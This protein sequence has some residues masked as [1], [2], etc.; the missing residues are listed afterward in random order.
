MPEAGACQTVTCP[1]GRCFPGDGGLRVRRGRRKLPPMLTRTNSI[2]LGVFL[3]AIVATAGLVYRGS[4][5]EPPPEING[6]LSKDTVELETRYKAF[7]Q[8][9]K[10]N[11]AVFRQGE[12]KSFVPLGQ[13]QKEIKELNAAAPK[14]KG[15]TAPEIDALVH[16][17]ASI[18]ASAKVLD[19]YLMMIVNK[20]VVTKAQWDA[21]NANAEKANHEWA[22]WLEA[23]KT[24]SR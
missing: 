17:A 4:G 23:S 6:K 21:K 8:K 5:H 18:D 3:L 12:T 20:S 7:Q 16:L 9:W 1:P 14:L 13:L 11:E 10:E 19:P 22:I 2:F 24:L 15:L